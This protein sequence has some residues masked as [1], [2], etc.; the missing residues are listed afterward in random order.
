MSYHAYAYLTDKYVLL[1]AGSAFGNNCGPLLISKKK[2]KTGEVKALSIAIPGKFTT[3][4]FLLSLAYPEAKNKEEMLFSE[5]ESSVLEGKKNAGLII[6]ENRFTY[7]E[8]GLQKIRDLGEYWEEETKL[9]IPLGGIVVRRDIAPDF[10]HKINRVLRRSV[11][12]ALENPLATK[13]FVR[14]YAQEMDEKVMYQHIGLYVNDFTVDLGEK[15][16]KAVQKLFD[17]AVE[18][19]VIPP[20]KEHIFLD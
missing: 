6:H 17:I 11:E 9:P 13:D 5:I 3:A 12:F 1:D 18:K 8:K 4:N 2:Y 7:E 16:R 10:Q 19:E 14:Q 15:G 20:V